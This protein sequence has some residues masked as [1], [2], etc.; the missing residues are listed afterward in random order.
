MLEPLSFKS[1]W[2]VIEKSAIDPLGPDVLRFCMIKG[3]KKEIHIPHAYRGEFGDL[4]VR[5][6]RTAEKLTIG[7]GIIKPHDAGIRMLSRNDSRIS[8]LKIRIIRSIEN[9]LVELIFIPHGE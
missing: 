5:V 3:V 1:G 8:T 2:L 9:D 6:F 4:M 7:E